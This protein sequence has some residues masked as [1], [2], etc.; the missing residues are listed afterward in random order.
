MGRNIYCSVSDIN[1]EDDF[2][3]EQL[4]LIDGETETDSKTSK[5]KGEDS[6]DDED[7]ACFEDCDMNVPPD[8]KKPRNL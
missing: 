5:K 8:S 3:E 4:A 1:W 2:D 7:L 6:F